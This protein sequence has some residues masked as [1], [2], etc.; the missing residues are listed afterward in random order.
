MDQVNKRWKK[1]G[2]R[3]TGSAQNKEVVNVKEL[4]EAT[5]HKEEHQTAVVLGKAQI[6]KTETPDGKRSESPS[7]EEGQRSVSPAFSL[8]SESTSSS[9]SDILRDLQG[10]KT[11]SE[12]SDKSSFPGPR[13]NKRKSCQ[14]RMPESNQLLPKRK[15]KKS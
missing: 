13:A 1:S 6:L 9:S 11:C 2:K 12:S 15:R 14:P 4:P 10:P 7:L 8:S 3:K 5:E